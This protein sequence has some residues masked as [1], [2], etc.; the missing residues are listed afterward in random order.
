MSK[1][2]PTYTFHCPHCQTQLRVRER[3]F[4][5]REIQCPA[6]ETELLVRLNKAYQIE[7]EERGTAQSEDVEAELTE[8]KP[9]NLNPVY[10]GVT[11][12]LLALISYVYIVRP[13]LGEEP[14]TDHVAD[15][16]DES[17]VPDPV[18]QQLPTIE[19]AENNSGK[20]AVEPGV[21]I[22]AKREPVQ[23]PRPAWVP[24]GL[25]PTL[26]ERP[27]PE[28]IPI[29]EKWE[30]LMQVKLTRYEVPGLERSKVVEELEMLAGTTFIYQDEDARARLEMEPTEVTLD[31]QATG[32]AEMLAKT[33]EPVGL[34]FKLTEDQIVIYSVET[35]ETR[36]AALP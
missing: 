16:V 2:F 22:E 15:Q 8:K 32:F 10:W 6:C 4:V 7:V 5:N 35:E 24:R 31:L 11:C 21:E 17:P 26:A 23:A 36:E 9:L 28:P 33:L 14:V 30:A 13:Q 19:T 12:L 20:T 1:T 34:T 29:P 3:R 18:E 25:P 27:A